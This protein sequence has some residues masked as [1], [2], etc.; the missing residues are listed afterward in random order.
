MLPC[1]TSVSWQDLE[2]VSFV[3]HAAGLVPQG[4]GLEEDVALSAQ[5]L[6]RRVGALDFQPT[7]AQAEYAQLGET[8]KLNQL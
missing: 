3:L 5:Q 6:C 7:K 8:Q 1:C 4:H 2:P